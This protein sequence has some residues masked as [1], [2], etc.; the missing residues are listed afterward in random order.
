MYLPATYKYPIWLFLFACILL[1]GGGAYLISRPRSVASAQ[2]PPDNLELQVHLTIDPSHSLPPDSNTAQQIGASLNLIPA[3]FL[4]P[5]AWTTWGNLNGTPILVGVTANSPDTAN[6]VACAASTAQGIGLFVANNTSRKV[7][8]HFAIPLPTGVYRIERLSFTTPPQVALRTIAISAEQPRT[9]QLPLRL[10]W[11]QGVILQK[12]NLV[13]KTDLLAPGEFAIYRFT[14]ETHS[15]QQAF[16]KVFDLL[17]QFA[18]QRPSAANRLRHILYEGSPAFHRLLHPSPAPDTIRSVRQA[19]LIIGQAQSLCRNY[20]VDS[21]VSASL[22]NAIE[23]TLNLLLNSISSIGMIAMEIAPEMALNP[24][25]TTANPATQDANVSVQ[26][27]LSNGGPYTISL[28]KLG[29]QPLK[30]A[31]GVICT[32]SDSA[33]F[34]NLAPGQIVLANYLIHTT[35]ENISALPMSCIAEV[36]YTASGGPIRVLLHLPN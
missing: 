13:A 16:Y 24:V 14:E 23:N 28:V 6:F 32:P 19:A 20:E 1:G 36:I 29:M 12:E 18:I 9:S 33:V 7:R 34:P 4:N 5:S 30:T 11:M 17:H 21:V 31:S 25:I 35:A 3:P 8:L 26:L 10:H 27:A 22:G 2:T 15:L